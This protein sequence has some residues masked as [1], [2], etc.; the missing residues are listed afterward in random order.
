M[1]TFGKDNTAPLVSVIMPAY[2]AADYIGAAIRS[3]MAQTLTDWELLVLDDGSQDD[4]CAIVETLAAEDGR[5]RLIPAEENAGVAAVRNRG[6]D[7]SRGKF[8]ALLDSDDVWL[9]EKLE[10]QLARMA[11]CGADL[12]CCSY[13]IIDAAGERAKA[14]Y[15]VPERIDLELLLRENVIGCST[16]V[17]RRESLGETR[18]RTDFFHED[19]VLWLRLLQDGCRAVGC[20]Q[21]LAQWRYIPSSRSFNKVKSARNRWRIYRRL[22]KLP[23]VKSTGLLLSYMLAGLRKYR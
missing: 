12:C 8:I 21:V 1:E 3:V 14:D 15:C 4:T 10:T 2:N 6:I 5:I 18:F 9:P 7:M 16:V 20:R 17:L 22:L 11:R 19:Y 23:L 13:A